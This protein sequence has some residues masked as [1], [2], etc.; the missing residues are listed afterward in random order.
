MVPKKSVFM[1]INKNRIPW[2]LKKNC[3]DWVTLWRTVSH[4]LTIYSHCF[5]TTAATAHHNG[6]KIFLNFI[7]LHFQEIFP[8]F[9]YLKVHNVQIFWEG[10]KNLKKFPTLILRYILSIFK[11]SGWLLQILLPSH[12]IWTL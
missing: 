1:N 7:L 10:H 8:Q 4:V 11:K 9:F 12:N 6:V 5:A 2:E 3:V